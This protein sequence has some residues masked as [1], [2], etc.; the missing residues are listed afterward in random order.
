[1]DATGTRGSG[2]SNSFAS[3]VFVRFQHIFKARSVQ[4][5]SVQHLTILLT[6]GITSPM[7][8]F[9]VACAMVIDSYVIQTLMIRYVEFQTKS[10]VFYNTFNTTSSG[11]NS[12]GS[13]RDSLNSDSSGGFAGDNNTPNEGTHSASAQDSADGRSSFSIE[14]DT[15]QLRL[16]RQDSLVSR[17]YEEERLA[18]LDSICGGTWR[19][20]HHTVWLVYYCCVI[21][22]SALLF[23]VVGDARGLES[24]VSV[25]ISGLVVGAFFRFTLSSIISFVRTRCVS[26][27]ERDFASFRESKSGK[28]LIDKDFSGENGGASTPEPAPD[29]HALLE[30]LMPPSDECY[31]THGLI[32]EPSASYQ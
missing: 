2:G 21:F 5:L 26:S 31:A 8:A 13:L 23:D 9:V 24:A 28:I 12:S 20:V 4:A 25:P 7:L 16:S 10:S 27:E 15:T 29:K 18:E 11:S 19:S 1:M 32:G 14:G 30:R 3:S 17:L 22:Y 6:F